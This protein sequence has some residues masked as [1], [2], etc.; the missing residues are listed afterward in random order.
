MGKVIFDSRM[1]AAI[2]SSNSRQ[3]NLAVKFALCTDVYSSS[4]NLL[5]CLSVS[6]VTYAAMTLNVLVISVLRAMKQ[7]PNDSQFEVGR[8]IS[9]T[10]YRS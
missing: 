6:T 4:I 8:L 7:S 3:S 1:P 9:S 2:E 10:F 5:A